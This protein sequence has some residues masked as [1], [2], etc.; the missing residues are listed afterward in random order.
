M[1]LVADPI[2]TPTEDEKDANRCQRSTRKREETV[3]IESRLETW[4]AP[5]VLESEGVVDKGTIYSYLDAIC[6]KALSILA[7]KNF[8]R[9]KN[10]EC[11]LS[12]QNW[13]SENHLP[14]EIVSHL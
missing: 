7:R 12:T 8:S 2:L 4:G 1:N 3:L 5:L 9:R 14:S 6:K 13:H 10:C 11:L